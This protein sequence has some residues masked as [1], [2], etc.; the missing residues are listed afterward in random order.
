MSLYAVKANK[1][2]KIADD[3]KL[4]Y[5]NLGF[6]IAKLENGKLV[7]EKEETPE[8]K[9]IIKLQTKIKELEAE[10]KK[11]KEESKSKGEGKKGEG[12]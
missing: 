11:A 2:Y 7:F 10:L 3:E 5:I 9:E 4:K 12:K 6:K 8:S 1:Q